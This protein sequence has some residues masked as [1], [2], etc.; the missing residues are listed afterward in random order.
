[1]RY[2]QICV[3]IT[4]SILLFSS[5]VRSDN[6]STP[7]IN[8]SFVE[9]E[10]EVLSIKDININGRWESKDNRLYPILEFKGKS[11]IVVETIMGSFASSYE[12]D[13][14]FL[15]VKTDKSDLLFE[16]VS[17]DSIIG[18][19]FAKGVWIKEK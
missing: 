5:C 13:E 14:E 9:S 7:A 8:D 18:S 2:Y 17:E 15:R 19:G 3:G 11:T 12:R 16:I 6:G 4:F 10:P 1:M